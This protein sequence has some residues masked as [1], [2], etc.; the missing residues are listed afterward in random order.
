MTT[1]QTSRTQSAHTWRFYRSGGFDQ[2]RLDTVDD[3][4]SLDQLDQKLWVA[5]SCPSKGLQFDPLTLAALDQDNDGY[6]RAHELITS[7]KWTASLLNDRELLALGADALPLSAINTETPEGVRILEAAKQILAGLGKAD[8]EHIACADTENSAV[9]FAALPLNG[10]GV[11][12][13]ES[14]LKPQLR[15]LISTILEKLG[16]TLDRCGTNGIN[17]E[18][19]K[20]FFSEGRSFAIW[21]TLP[22]NNSTLSPLGG[23]TEIALN[24]LLAVR[25]KVDDYFTRCRLAGF[26]PR[27]AALLNASDD[28]LK[29]LSPLNLAQDI[30]L[31]ESHIAALPLATISAGKALPL[32]GTE[33]N[34]AWSAGIQALLEQVVTPQLGLREVLTEQEWLQLLAIFSA[35]IAWLA[36]KPSTPLAELE[37]NA[38]DALLIP[39]LETE[40]KALVDADAALVETAEAIASADRLARYTRDLARLARNFASFQNFYS[41]TEKALFQAGTLYL[42]GRSCDLCIQV[43]DPAKHATLATLSG[44]YLAYCDCVRGENGGMEQM[45]I[46]AA[47]TDGDSDQLM[48]GRN[49][50]FYDRLGRDWHATITRIIDHPISLRQSLWSPYKKFVRLLGEQIQKIASSK[51]KLAESAGASSINTLANK[52]NTAISLPPAT[53]KPNSPAVAPPTTPAPPVAPFDVA[54]FAGIFAAIGLAVGA[55]GTALANLLHSFLNLA[56]WQ[57]PLAIAGLMLVISGPSFLLALFKLRNRN[58]GPLLDANG[59]AVNTR[60]KINIPFGRS[61]T[62]LATL[63]PGA[64]SSMQ[65][66]YAEKRIPWLGYAIAFSFFT[67]TILYLKFS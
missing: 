22:D 54:R 64:L 2:V 67:A 29:A 33:L 26:D 51:E 34:P 63:P 8:S 12:T 58:L 47:F 42:D 11:V 48:V 28:E 24:T 7:L 14:T 36:Q 3:L 17:A 40:L 57:M 4:L 43:L 62:K 50:L 13:P 59:W 25:E 5:L 30:K 55:I 18:L 35:R 9:A 39:E 44:I 27:A 45:I 20:Q 46:A 56:W 38:L 65:D 37:P 6:I 66:P 60:A 61:L 32:T 23:L 21:R 41:G 1:L 19:A 15:H 52:A 49:G 16:G 53:G 10:D 31:G